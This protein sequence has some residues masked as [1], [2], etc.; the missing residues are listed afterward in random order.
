MKNINSVSCESERAEKV[1]DALFF[2]LSAERLDAEIQQ[3]IEKAANSFPIPNK[4]M[5]S[6][7]ELIEV[8][9]D[10]IRCMAPFVFEGSAFPTILEAKKKAVVLL[11]RHYQSEGGQGLDAALLD[12]KSDFQNGFH[13]VIEQ[14]KQI[15]AGI[16]MSKYREYN[17]AAHIPPDNALQ[18]E[19]VQVIFTRCGEY[20]PPDITR[21]PPE[22]FKKKIPSLIQVILQSDAEISRMLTPR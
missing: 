6:H 2:S 16:A 10:F 11:N 22:M 20:F 17:Y 13:R 21:R 19:M 5:E 12:A 15:V 1:L 18:K 3:P 8:C 4:P 9:G 14:L 7:D